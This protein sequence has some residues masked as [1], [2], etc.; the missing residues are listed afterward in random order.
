MW[1][2]GSFYSDRLNLYRLEMALLTFGPAS[3]PNL[4]TV[5]FVRSSLNR[6]S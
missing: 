2:Q 3:K 6:L 4:S 5:N 1:K